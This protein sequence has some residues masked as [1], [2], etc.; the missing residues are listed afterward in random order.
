MGD[1]K[2]TG[3][4]IINLVGIDLLI[5]VMNDDVACV[6]DRSQISKEQTYNF[7]VTCTFPIKN[8]FRFT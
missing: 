8:N 4:L 6:K 7:H 2:D 3:R 1:F 5:S